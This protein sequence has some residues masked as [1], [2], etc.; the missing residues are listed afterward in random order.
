MIQV[1]LKHSVCPAQA[2]D[3]SPRRS[4]S[5]NVQTFGK[6]LSQELEARPR[7]FLGWPRRTS[8]QMLVKMAEQVRLDKQAGQG[9]AAANSLTRTKNRLWPEWNIMDFFSAQ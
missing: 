5:G 9:G 6:N 7:Q 8:Q 1:L 4:T 3:Q 2:L